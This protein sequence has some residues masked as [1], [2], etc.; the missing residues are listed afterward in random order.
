MV[1]PDSVAS[2]DSVDGSYAPNCTGKLRSGSGGVTVGMRA[3]SAG[4]F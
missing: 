2:H 3:F 4:G 1:L